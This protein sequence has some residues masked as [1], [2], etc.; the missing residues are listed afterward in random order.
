MSALGLLGAVNYRDSLAAQLGGGRGCLICNSWD[1]WL[2]H[3][4]EKTAYSYSLS[5]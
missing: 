3:V 2:A 1:G 4:G 5:L